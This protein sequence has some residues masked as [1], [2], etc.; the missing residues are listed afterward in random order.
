MTRRRLRLDRMRR[1]PIIHGPPQRTLTRD[2][3]T[4]QQYM[5]RLVRRIV[6]AYPGHRVDVSVE[7]NPRDFIE[8]RYVIRWRVR[9]RI[10]IIPESRWS[11]TI[12]PPGSPAPARR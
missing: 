7:Q 8:N 2:Q 9:P 5:D 6:A 12:P 1:H 10:E 3:W 11:L 4:D